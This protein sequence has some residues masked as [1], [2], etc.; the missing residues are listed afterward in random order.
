MDGFLD[1]RGKREKVPD[2]KCGFTRIADR[3][4]VQTAVCFVQNM[5]KP[6]L[7]NSLKKDW[8]QKIKNVKNV[9]GFI[10]SYKIVHRIGKCKRERKKKPHT[11]TNSASHITLLSTWLERS[12]QSFLWKNFWRWT[13]PW[14]GITW[15]I[16]WSIEQKHAF[17]KK[18]S[19]TITILEYTVYKCWLMM[20]RNFFFPRIVSFTSHCRPSPSKAIEEMFKTSPSHDSDTIHGVKITRGHSQSTRWPIYKAN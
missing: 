14:V 19:E 9:Q 17:K 10:A 4:Y 18:R 13:T 6:C 8:M 3:W 11:H 20:F 15:Y 1:C 12:L 2:I 5:S 7:L 16:W